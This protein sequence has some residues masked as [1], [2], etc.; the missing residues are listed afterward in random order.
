MSILGPDGQPVAPTRKL[1]DQEIIH[2]MGTHRNQLERLSIGQIQSGLFTEWVTNQ[3]TDKLTAIQDALAQAGVTVDL[4]IDPAGFPA[5][6]QARYEQVQE[7]EK[8]QA[9]G[10]ISLEDK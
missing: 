4:T 1:T 3:L 7:E 6:A 8:A 10:K 5:W 2:A 9:M